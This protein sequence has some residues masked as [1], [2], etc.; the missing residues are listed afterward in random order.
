MSVTGASVG[1]VAGAFLRLKLALVRNGVRQTAGRSAAFVGAVVVTLLFGG[2]GLLGMVALRGHE[3][4]PEAA[5]VLVALLALGWAFMPLFVGGA[6]ETLD[7]AR[8]AMLPLRPNAMLTGQ[9]VASV[10]G[11]GPLFTL[12][13]VTG[14]AVTVADGAAGV[15]AAV[16]AVPLALLTCTTLARALATANAGLLSSRRGRDLAVLSGVLIAV[17]VQA[18]NLGVSKLSGE[19]GAGPLEALADVLRWVPPAAAVEGVRAVGDGSYGRAAAALGGSLLVWLLLLGWW[20]RTL[21]KLLTAPD[22]STLGAPETAK[23]RAARSGSGPSRWLPAGRAGAAAQRTL[24][25]GWRDPKTKMGW[26]SAL[27][28]GLLMPVVT[29]A[30]GGTS[31]YNAFWASALLGLLMYNQFGQD[32]S[33]F[34]LVS[35]TIATSRDAYLELYGRALAVA[36]VAVPFTSA[37]VALSAG[38]ADDWASAPDAMGLALA[39]LGALIGL[40]AVTSARF[41]YSIPQDSPMK[42]VAPGQ[43]AL[44]WFSIL[45]G[46]L[47]GPVLCAP[48]IALVVTLHMSDATGW[49]WTTLPLGAGY[50]VLMAWAGLRLAAPVTVRRLP[51]ILTAVSRA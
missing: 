16:V 3:H 10:V 49:L 18:L 40:G 20:R 13:L 48:V 11:L 6:D 26:A 33:G 8:L 42:N 2:L 28:V 44:A 36:L 22:S 9:L 14:A 51:E 30:Q 17:G 38:L 24:R 31:P 39:L 43:G 15:V 35:Q 50:G 1:V 7:P 47:A 46:M 5:V 41:P 45:G 25:Y 27:G 19:N 32:Y 29:A 34:W 37:V 21:T 23:S 12:L 4:G